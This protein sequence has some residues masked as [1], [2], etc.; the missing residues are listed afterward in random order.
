MTARTAMAAAI[1][2][3]GA[4]GSGKAGSDEASAPPSGTRPLEVAGIRIGMTAKSAQTALGAAGWKL[5]PFLGDSWKV[6]VDRLVASRRAAS[7]GQAPDGLG[8]WDAS[9]GDETLAVFLRPAADGGRVS[10]LIYRAPIA[11]RS[12]T[13]FRAQLASRYGPPASA[14][15]PLVADGA[16]W[17]S[18]DEAGCTRPG[19]APERPTLASAFNDG[20]GGRVSLQLNEGASDVRAWERKRDAA[21]KAAS[22]SPATSF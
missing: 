5:R 12:S 20:T 22:G 17:C 4:C 19:T 21:V 11:G 3:L 14:A 6:T 16:V 18:P 1:L 10:K 13:E 7:L 9:K 8:G 2:L 15:S